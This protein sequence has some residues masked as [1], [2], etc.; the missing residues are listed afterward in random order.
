VTRLGVSALFFLVFPL[1]LSA[2][3]QPDKMADAM[4]SLETGVIC[5]PPSVG[6]T[7]APGTVAGT[8]HIIEDEPPF[9]S[10]NNRVPAVLGIGFGVKSMA[11]AVEGIANV[12]MTI[13]HPPMGPMRATSQSFQSSI[14]GLDPSLTFYQ[15]D[16]DY[17]LLPGIWQIQ[18]EKDGIILYRTTFEVLPPAKVPELAAICGY[19]AL[20]S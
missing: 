1:S 3:Q 2:A 11:D 5:A 16:F 10:R 6:T 4:I 9:V 12:T 13:T 20:L 15:F 7:P 14:T 17:E 8:T 18:A 19:E